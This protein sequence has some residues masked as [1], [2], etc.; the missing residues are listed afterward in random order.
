MAVF[1]DEAWRDKGSLE[2][3]GIWSLFHCIILPYF[4]ISI[5]WSFLWRPD[6]CFYLHLQ[7]YSWGHN[8]AALSS[9]CRLIWEDSFA[10]YAQENLSLKQ[11]WQQ[12]SWTS[13]LLL[14]FPLNFYWLTRWLLLQSSDVRH[15]SLGFYF[16]QFIIIIILQNVHD[17][18]HSFDR[19]WR[20]HLQPRS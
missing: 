10:E 14:N 5:S 19:I 2:P 6:F 11:W 9:P 15:Q 12:K 13:A 20:K 17:Q 7:S 3:R 8:E 18:I 16:T 1:E 4:Y